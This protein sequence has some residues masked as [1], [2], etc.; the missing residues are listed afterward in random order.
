VEDW[1]WGILLNSQEKTKK[2]ITANGNRESGI[3]N[4]ELRSQ[5]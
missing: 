2:W 1:E 3:E 5:G 4:G